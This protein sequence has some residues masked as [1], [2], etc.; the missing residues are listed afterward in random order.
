VAQLRGMGKA[1]V[2]RILVTISHFNEPSG[3]AVLRVV[4]LAC[5]ITSIC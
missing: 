2:H 4:T 1:E 5:W 3:L